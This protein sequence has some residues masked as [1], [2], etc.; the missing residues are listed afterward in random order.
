MNWDLGCRLQDLYEQYEIENMRFKRLSE[1]SAG[2]LHSINPYV[3]FDP[4]NSQ[5]NNVMIPGCDTYFQVSV[6]NI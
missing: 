5:F 1:L 3:N 6:C 2:H 4:T